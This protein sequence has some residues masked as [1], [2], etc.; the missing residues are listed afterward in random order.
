MEQLDVA[1][2]QGLPPLVSAN[3]CLRARDV[4]G[5][6]AVVGSQA[7]RNRKRPVSESGGGIADMIRDAKVQKSTTQKTP[8]QA[9]HTSVVVESRTSGA[10]IVGKFAMFRKG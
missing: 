5:G 10:N 8:V 4:A 3:E 7:T 6:I 9:R 2:R 1:A